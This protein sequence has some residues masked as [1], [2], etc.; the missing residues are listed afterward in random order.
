MNTKAF[1]CKAVTTVKMDEQWHTPKVIYRK[2]IITSFKITVHY[3]LVAGNYSPMDH[4]N[5]Q[6]NQSCFMTEL[7]SGRNGSECYWL[8]VEL[9]ELP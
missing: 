4:H 2:C 6:P 7:D 5:A 9:T 8:R 1:Y 3:D